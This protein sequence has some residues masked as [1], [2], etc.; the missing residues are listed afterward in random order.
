MV[1]VSHLHKLITKIMID[2]CH[3]LCKLIDCV[4]GG[5]HAGCDCDT[6]NTFYSLG[7]FS[8]NLLALIVL[9]RKLL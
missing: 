9:S 3:L 8:I 6:V 4:M 2:F 7:S 5:L 1:S